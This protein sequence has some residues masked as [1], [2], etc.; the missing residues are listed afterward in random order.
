[1]RAAEIFG[2]VAVACYFVAMLL[3]IYTISIL[4]NPQ[5]SHLGVR[6]MKR[7]QSLQATPLW[8]EVEPIV[9]WLGARIAP[10]LPARYRA[11]LDR[12]LV[13]SGEFWGLMPQEFIALSLV[14]CGTGLTLGSMYGIVLGKG[15]LYVV[16][17]ACAGLALPY[18]YISGLEQERLQR[19]QNS[20]PHVIDLLA[21]GLSAGLDFPA[22]VRQ[23]VEKSGNPDDPL[24]EELSLILQ[25]LEVGKTR[26]EALLRFSER[27]PSD[28]VREFVVTVVQSEERGNPLEETLRI[29]AQASR[30]RR[31]VRAEE[32]ASKAGMKMMLPMV[33]LLVAVMLLIVGPLALTIGKTLQ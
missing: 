33:L 17:G 8:P 20:L 24:R 19:V 30:Q 3:A 5:S 21:L 14:S 32:T 13:A 22:S 31:S 27:V 6:G 23:V 25:E 2:Y 10:I 18:L 28:S 29:Q 16:I 9:R 4:P 11:E 7:A 15:M 26:K 12:M 1:M